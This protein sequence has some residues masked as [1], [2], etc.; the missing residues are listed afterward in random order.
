MMQCQKTPG[1]IELLP[2][3]LQAPESRQQLSHPSGP[4]RTT[5]CTVHTIPTLSWQLQRG[6]SVCYIVIGENDA[7][8]G[9]TYYNA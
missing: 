3:A 6:N 9:I 5:L 1:N 2:R 8:K 7:D 4:P